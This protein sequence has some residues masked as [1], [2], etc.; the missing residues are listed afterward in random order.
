MK[1]RA[2]PDSKQDVPRS[3]TGK[4]PPRRDE[5]PNET[6]N[7][8]RPQPAPGISVRKVTEPHSEG[9]HITTVPD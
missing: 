4:E 9:S 3:N 7:A 5:P 1:S 8:Q 6:P 2:T